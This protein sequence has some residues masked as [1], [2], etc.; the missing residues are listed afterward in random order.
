VSVTAAVLDEFG[1]QIKSWTLIPSRG[2]RFEL[3][4]DGDL[5]YSKLETGRHT[6]PEEIKTLLRQKLGA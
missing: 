3:T 5:I 6:N 1:D 4:V 2:G